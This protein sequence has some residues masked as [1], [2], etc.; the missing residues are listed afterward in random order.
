MKFITKRHDSR[1]GDISIYKNERTGTKVMCKEKASGDKKQFRSDVHMARQRMGLQNQYLH[2]MLGWSTQ[3]KKELCSTHHY[4][5]MY[6]EYPTSDLRNETAERKK[7]GS[8][9][10]DHELSN[11]TTHGLNGLGYLHH[12]KLSHGDVRPSLISAER[13][14]PTQEAN[15]FRLLDRLSD[16]SPIEKAQVNNMMNKKELFMSPQ[17]WRHI[18]TKGKKKPHYNKQKNDLFALGMSILGTGNHG[19]LK[20][21]Y[22]K[23]GE[24]HHENLNHHLTKFNSKYEHNTALVNVVNNLCAVDESKR[25]DTNMMLTGRGQTS[26]HHEG[27]QHVTVHEHHEADIPHRPRRSSGHESPREHVKESRQRVNVNHSG[28]KQHSGNKN[29]SGTKHRSGNKHR[30]GEVEVEGD[31]FFSNPTPH[32]KPY[33]QNVEYVPVEKHHHEPVVHSRPIVHHEPVVH[34]RPIVHHEPVVQYRPVVHHEP[35]VHSRPVV[36]HEPVVHSRPIVHH[37]PVVHS[38]PIVHHP[39]EV[40][41]SHKPSIV[42]GESSVSYGKPRVVRTYIDHSSKRSTRDKDDSHSTLLNSTH[43]ETVSSSRPHHETFVRTTAPTHTTVQSRPHR[44]VITQSDTY[45]EPITNHHTVVRDS[46]NYAE[47]IT[48]H[49][50]VVRGTNT[51]VESTSNHHNVNRGTTNYVEPITNHHTVVRESN[52]YVESTTNQHNGARGSNTYVENV[53]N[54]HQEGGYTTGKKKS[55]VFQDAHFGKVVDMPDHGLSGPE[56]RGHHHTHESSLV[57]KRIIVVKDSEGNIIEER[58]E[59]I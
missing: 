36:H 57:G 54:H 32:Y 19:S 10:T 58:E 18:N 59:R 27:T 1:F 38:R 21:C 42:S 47:P 49:H 14:G 6:Y 55:T 33:V 40:K 15:E 45:T 24:F 23:G 48:N 7:A 16:P 53:T 52:T 56:H 3:T 39:T 12:K 9:L 51:Y 13:I 41:S 35:V 26:H 2:K 50:N 46:R 22:K 8:S 29:Y 31:D 44:E 43:Q 34:S 37:E 28:T 30:G 17:L 20:N 5:K 11:A 4:V 25:P